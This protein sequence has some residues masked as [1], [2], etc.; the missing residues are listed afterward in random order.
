MSH[1]IATIM[2][3][4]ADPGRRGDEYLALVDRLWPRGVRKDVL[5]Y[6]DWLRDVAPSPALRTWYAHDVARFEEF[7][8]RY[9]AELAR[10]PAAAVLA[11]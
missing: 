7:A 3:V 11:D 6:D 1:D 8:H 9:R 2:R 4:Y 10:E 5:D